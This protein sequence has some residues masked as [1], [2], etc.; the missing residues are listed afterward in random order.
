MCA[1]NLQDWA[2]SKYNGPVP[3][4]LI[5]IQQLASGLMFI[6]DQQH[7]HRDIC[8][9]NILISVSGDRLIISDFGLCKQVHDSGSYS[10]SNRD[11][12]LK[13]LAPERIENESDSNYRVTIASD[14]W[15][16]GCAF[17]YFITKGCHPF[18]HKD[19]LEMLK[20]IK[21]GKFSL[22]GMSSSI[23]SSIKLIRYVDY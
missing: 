10:V 6:H 16:M 14:T 11:G 20:K 19:V 4:K 3:A 15:A 7:V 22:K 5:G 2:E 13:W 18:D 1:C 12:H 9:G 8:P 21:K 17:Y 23:A